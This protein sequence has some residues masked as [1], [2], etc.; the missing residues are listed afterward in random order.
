MTKEKKITTI[1]INFF[2]AVVS[3]ILCGLVVVISGETP[4]YLELLMNP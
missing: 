2:F 3:C 4:T 1:E